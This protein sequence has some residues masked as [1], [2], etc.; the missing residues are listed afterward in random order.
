MS[1]VVSLAIEGPSVWYAHTA[2]ANGGVVSIADECLTEMHAAIEVLRANPLEI[3][4]LSPADFELSKCRQMMSEVKTILDDGVGFAILDRLPIEAFSADEAKAI[5]WVLM[6]MLGNTVA[7]TWTG[8]LLYDVLDT[9]RKEELGAGVR[10]SKTNGGQGYHTD[11]SYNLPPDYVALFCL[12]GSKAGGVSGLVSFAAAHNDLL[13][14]N[15]AA[16]ERLFEPFFFERYKEFAPGDSAVSRYP[17]FSDDN[18]RLEV[19]LSTKRVRMGYQAA[20]EEMDE[21]AVHAMDALDEVL[22]DS[23]LGKSFEFLPGQ[24]QII[25]NRKL[26]H[27]R[28]AYEDWPDAERRRHLVR[29][30]VR[31]EGRRF[32]A[33]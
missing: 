9:G 29:I 20:N 14:R 23:T 27:R 30:W 31:K 33:G 12:R 5:E 21:R 22:E 4:A 28:T 24:I 3:T 10:G 15:P 26:G 2:I 6:S 17:V 11:N 8:T 25:N 19:R 32:Y 16:L 13:E 1:A 7:Q 18:G